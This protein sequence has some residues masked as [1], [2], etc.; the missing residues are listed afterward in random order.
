MRKNILLL[1]V[2]ITITNIGINS[3]TTVGLESFSLDPE[4]YYNGSI[5]H[6]GTIGSTETF[7]YSEAEA[8]FYV[9]YTLEN[10]YDYWSGF[11]YSNQTDLETA[12]YTNYSAYSPTGGGATGSSNYVIA[13]IYGGSEISFNQPVDLTSVQITNS[14]W[15]YKYISGEDG[16][17]HDYEPDDY[18]ILAIRGKY[19]N[20]SYSTPINFYLSDFT[21]GNST[22]VSDW[23]EVDLSSLD[24]V[25]ALEF[26]L[27]ALD[28]WTPYYFCMDNLS[29]NN[30]L[31]VK[32]MLSNKINVYPNP[33]RKSIRI[34][35]IFNAT[36]N[37][38]DNMGNIVRTIKEY[39]QND[40][41]DIS[42][43]N[44]GVYVIRVIQQNKLFSEKIIIE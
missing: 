15:A 43:L 35:E 2:L 9:D 36:V 18:F 29:Y 19:E 33:A 39:N 27:S 16:S 11:A 31:S 28:T 38:V 14:V 21:N 1:T 23:T 12:N 44:S 4:S 7:F 22:I 20:G 6:S 32:K 17:G 25:V 42:D 8:T 37:I 24:A 3:Q 26:Q 13:Y 5:D 41:I 40:E 10:S 34:R 30:T